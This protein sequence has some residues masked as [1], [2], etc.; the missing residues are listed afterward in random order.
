[1]VLMNND[2][3]CVIGGLYVLGVVHGVSNRS[4]WHFVSSD[5]V[6]MEWVKVGVLDTGDTGR[7]QWTTYGTVLEEVFGVRDR[8]HSTHVHLRLQK[9]TNQTLTAFWRQDAETEW[10]AMNPQLNFAWES[11]EVGLYAAQC[12]EYGNAS[13]DFDYIIDRSKISHDE[14]FGGSAEPGL[15]SHASCVGRGIGDT[16]TSDPSVSDALQKSVDVKGFSQEMKEVHLVDG[17]YSTGSGGLEMNDV[18]TIV[19]RGS[20]T[21]QDFVYAW[22]STSSGHFVKTPRYD[23]SLGGFYDNFAWNGTGWTPLVVRYTVSFRPSLVESKMVF[24][25]DGVERPTLIVTRPSEYKQPRIYIF[26]IAEQNS[27]HSVEGFVL[28]TQKGVGFDHAYTTGTRN[29]GADAG[30]VELHVWA[31][32]PDTLYYQGTKTTDVGGMI[33]VRD[34]LLAPSKLVRTRRLMEERPMNQVDESKDSFRESLRTYYMKHNRAKLT[35]LEDMVNEW[36]LKQ[37]EL[38]QLL[39]LKY[40]EALSLHR[41][42]S[43]SESS[44]AQ[45]MPKSPILLHPHTTPTPPLPSSPKELLGQDARV[46]TE[47]QSSPNPKEQVKASIKSHKFQ[48][49][50]NEESAL[51][52]AKS[53]NIPFL[54]RNLSLE[55]TVVGPAKVVISCGGGYFFSPLMKTSPMLVV[56]DLNVEFV[57]CNFV[58]S[59]SLVLSSSVSIL[60]QR[61]IVRF[62]RCAFSKGRSGLEID[63]SMVDFR[64]CRF[65]DV[66]YQHDGSSLSLGYRKIIAG[67]GLQQAA[68]LDQMFAMSPQVYMADVKFENNSAS[69]GGALRVSRGSFYCQRCEFSRNSARRDGGAIVL[70]GS[71]AVIIT[72][73]LFER[74]VATGGG[75]LALLSGSAIFAQVDFNFNFA[76]L[77]GGAIL[78]NMSA[79]PYK[80][81]RECDCKISYRV[82]PC[83]TAFLRCNF[84]NNSVIGSTK[85]VGNGGAIFF[86]GSGSASIEGSSF[87]QNFVGGPNGMGGCFGMK[88]GGRFYYKLG[89]S[90]YREFP[91]LRF[92][93]NGNPYLDPHSATLLPNG[94]GLTASNPYEPAWFTKELPADPRLTD[95]WPFYATGERFTGYFSPLAQP[96]QKVAS[97]GL[98]FVLYDGAPVLDG[99]EQVVGQVIFKDCNIYENMP[100]G[101]SACYMDVETHKQTCLGDKQL[102]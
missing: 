99:W 25:I 75:S 97:G 61:S 54:R 1:M 16:T 29:N 84:L 21:S 94:L 57:D 37:E 74:N 102:L 50:L 68:S 22:N 65:S 69:M 53:R 26:T 83:L 87:I 18:K 48:L 15:L 7:L 77:Y 52:E 73:S 13:V 10:T 35:D 90:D 86:L 88:D 34:S 39:S 58:F 14:V 24:F 19:L 38:D 71:A 33:E 47:A 44:M 96:G 76:R 46:D 20:V 40:G 23:E 78:Y 80:L 89:L 62:S 49:R 101:L 91:L 42:A 17:D 5:G 45:L 12:E 85:E 64:D 63:S 8:F 66:E 98:S 36:F 9:G 60:L 67:G 82:L 28:T 2:S 70:E 43:T 11:I 81:A 6:T 72:N 32:A 92:G 41:S 59:D 31:S 56:V 30:E 79:V 100:A 55:E 3:S 27:N 4:P 95:Q 51:L 93:F